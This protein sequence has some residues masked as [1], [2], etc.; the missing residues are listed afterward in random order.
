MC[1]LQPNVAGLPPGSDVSTV[2]SKSHLMSLSNN[3]SE[4][5]SLLSELDSVQLSAENF[6][7]GERHEIYGLLK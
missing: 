7:A 6:T 4:L 5:D 3:L 1:F 2:A